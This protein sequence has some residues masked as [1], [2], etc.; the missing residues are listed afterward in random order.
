MVDSIERFIRR[1]MAQEQRDS[2]RGLAVVVD[3]RLVNEFLHSEVDWNS[4]QRVHEELDAKYDFEFD[5]EVSEEE[6]H[7]LLNVLESEFN[8]ERFRD[9]LTSCRDD[10][11]AA[12]VGPFGLGGMVSGGDKDGGNV[13]TIQNAKQG[14]YAREQDG[15]ERRDYTG[16][17]NSAGRSFEGASKNSVGSEFTRSQLKG[18]KLRDGYTGRIEK[19]SQTSPDHVVSLSEFHKSGGYMLSSER[20]ADFATDPENL[21]SIRRDINQSKSDHD[22]MEWLEK[23]QSGR[24]QN[25]KEHYRIDPKR[26]QEKVEKGR[27][28]AKGH[29]PNTKEKVIYYGKEISTTGAYEGIKK[30]LQQAI[31]LVLCE[32]FKSTFDEIQDIYERGFSDG[33]DDGRFISVLKERLSRIAA[34]TV[35]K[36]QDACEGFRD[37]FISGFLSNLVTVIINMF[38]RTGKRIVRIIREGFFSLLRAIKI[39]C[40]PPEGMTTGQAAH[41]ASKLIAAGLATIGGIAVEQHID[42]MIKLAPGLE[43]F[44]DILTT[45]L[46]G[47]LT[48]LATTFIVYAID[49]IDVFKVNE[50]R[51]HEVV[52]GR[53][54]TSLNRM[55]EEGDALVN[56]LA[57]LPLEG[58]S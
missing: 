44:A 23:K 55:F 41:E 20:K 30:G 33:F 17:K 38:V 54:E 5:V 47:G 31:G 43:L 58:H 8:D 22:A 29:L 2:Q 36:W 4:V 35:A 57:H 24:E 19:G 34:R 52:M 18:D 14:V 45:V 51:R 25:N 53:F 28:S 26:L 21:A 27:A 12:V 46:I 40:F 13:T 42:N 11:L 3:D 7:E 1:K 49:K 39:L 10:V 6:V 56:N 50:Q 15:Y 16:A 37:G 32:F 9:L 48:G